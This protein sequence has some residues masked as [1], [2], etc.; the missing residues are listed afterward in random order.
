[1]IVGTLDSAARPYVR[2]RLALPRFGIVTRITLLVDTGADATYL[3]PRDGVRAGIPFD[4]LHDSVASLGI[5]G[6]STY[7]R[8]PAVLSFRDYKVRQ[9][10][11]Y[12]INVNIAKPGDVGTRLPSLLG[13]DVIRC[14]RMD[15]DPTDNRLE[16]TVRD[17]DFTLDTG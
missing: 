14:W 1:M 9:R 6:R 8:E 2:C 15:Y 16:F 4:L 11:G 5:G 7:F 17:A 12:R 3:H 10:Y 13:R